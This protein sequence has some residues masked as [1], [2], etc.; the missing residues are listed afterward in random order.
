MKRYTEREIRGL[1]AKWLGSG[2]SKAAFCKEEGLVKSTFYSWVK[3]LQG[4][5]PG[6]TGF[7]PL[8]LGQGLPPAEA[9]PVLRVNYGSG[10]SVD[11]FGPLDAGFI[12]ELC[13]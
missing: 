1:Y 10:V 4:Q 9:L 3:R 8:V 13:R 11:F 12:K 5:G 6:Q 7:A 2:K